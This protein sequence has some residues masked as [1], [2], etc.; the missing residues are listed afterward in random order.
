MVDKRGHVCIDS[1][2]KLVK[3]WTSAEVSFKES[4][5]QLVFKCFSLCREIQRMLKAQ[6]FVRMSAV[7]MREISEEIVSEQCRDI[8]FKSHKEA[9][10]LKKATLWKLATKIFNNQKRRCF[11]RYAL[12]YLHTITII[13]V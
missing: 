2:D 11:D 12:V 9:V 7:I 13:L 8:A 1:K 3:G 6:S 4:N 5:H 10:N